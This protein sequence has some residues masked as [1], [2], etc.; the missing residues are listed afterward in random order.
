MVETTKVLAAAR[1]QGLTQF[2]IGPEQVSQAVR[3]YAA[4]PLFKD[5]EEL[6]IKDNPYRR[7]CDPVA[8]AKM[9]FDRP[10]SRN[11]IL[12]SSALAAHRLLLNIYEN[13]LM[14]LPE[15]GLASKRADF[16][17]FYSDEGRLLGEVIRPRLE[18]HVFGFLEDGIQV[19]GRWTV[20][21]LRSHLGAIIEQHEKSELDI[22]AV[23]LGSK[24]PEKA[25]ISLLVQVASDFLTEASASARNVLGKFGSIQS[26]LFKILIDDYGYG[27][28]HAK[29]S[30]LFEN[31]LTTCGLVTQAH[32]YWQFYLSS[33]L[34]LANY[35][36]YVSLNHSRFFRYIGAFAFAE[37]MFS[38]TCRKISELLRKVLGSSVDTYYFD[39]HYHI[40][41]HHGRMA[42]DNLV[43]P[44][45][46]KHGEQF[47]SE[48]V[49]GLEEVRL[50][51]AI[52]D[53][54]FIAQTKWL[55]RADEYKA[56]GASVYNEIQNDE[57]RRSF[58][59]HVIREG[60][61]IS[62]SVSDADELVI[63]QSGTVD[64]VGDAGQAV[65][66]IEGEAMIIPSGRLHALVTPSEEAVYIICRSGDKESW[67]S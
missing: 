58:D 17:R 43:A 44:A 51:T 53:E 35:Y 27:V 25:A 31:T 54:D 33:S 14:F 21:A 42:F 22:S 32:A 50:L 40:D 67:S 38:H 47:G 61:C 45:I 12:G 64:C 3:L 20:E 19:T 56:L 6:I 16:D 34:A 59:R 7:P 29:H 37:A 23:V 52:A 8:I 55:D 11:E 57:K 2:Q 60:H 18:K 36:H 66:L 63:V 24:D 13:D 9:D 15:N 30:T 28:H 49:R 62:T 4:N 5:S 48:V 1:T 10:L 65:R 46:E 39:E 41:A 26:E